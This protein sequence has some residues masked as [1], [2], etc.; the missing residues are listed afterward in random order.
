M[1]QF[2]LKFFATSI[3]L[4]TFYCQGAVK[5][6]K[7]TAKITPKPTF[8]SE[9]P[10]WPTDN[11]AFEQGQALSYYIQATA[12]GKPESG[13]FGCVR[14]NGHKFHEGIDV[15][16]I[17]RTRKQVPL[18]SVYAVFNGEIAYINNNPGLSNYGKY[19]VIKH[20]TIGLQFYTLYAHLASL[21]NSLKIKQ[22]VFKG[23]LLGT[24]GNT[25]NFKIPMHL[26]HLHFEI[27]MQLGSE[28]SFVN[29]YRLQKFGT[30]NYHRDWNGFNLVGLDPLAFYHS[31]KRF[32]DF[33]K[34]QPIAFECILATSKIPY[35]IKKNS[36]LLTIPIDPKKTIQGWRIAF[37]WLGVPL[38]WTPLYNSLKEKFS[39]NY[40]RREEFIQHGNRNIIE[41]D[42]QGNLTIGKVLQRQLFL[43]FEEIFSIQ[44]VVKKTVN[45]PQ[46]SKGQSLT[47]AAS[48]RL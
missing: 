13:T 39:I 14:N 24:M 30:P 35:F 31:K 42:W 6:S 44:H 21:S 19:I 26:A 10:R 37:N 38:K 47:D 32:V 1:V 34:E 36:A 46:K 23:T 11:K 40:I 16:A 8:F 22:P 48:M 12:S 29:W 45:I 3:Y 9:V 28:A 33:L 15:K 18:D 41:W 27:G 25:S 2:C 7:S 20:Q 5:P 4:F 43:L 17:K